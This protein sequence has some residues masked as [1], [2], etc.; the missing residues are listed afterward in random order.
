MFIV[1]ATHAAVP[2]CRMA[3]ELGFWVAVIDPRGAFVRPERFPEADQ[4]VSAWPGPALEEAA[5]DAGSFVVTLTH[6]PKVDL[7]ALA[8]ALASPAGYIGAMGSRRTHRERVARLREQGFDDDALARIRGPV[9]L[10]LG[11]RSPEETALAILAEM[12]AVR[13]R[14]DAKPLF[15][16]RG[17][18]HA[19]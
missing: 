5:L 11:S 7:P 16:G 18:I 9:G 10:D 12:V 1:G 17:R 4:V 15:E 2:L 13:N 3:N 14:R 19:G 8:Q 6:D